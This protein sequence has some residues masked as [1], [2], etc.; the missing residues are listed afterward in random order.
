[1]F[2]LNLGNTKIPHNKNTAEM[3][4]VKM[5]PPG[6]VLLPMSQNIGAPAT[7]IVKVGEYVKVGQLIAE[8]SAPISSPIYASVSGTVTKIESYL[9]KDGRTVP[10]IRIESDGLMTLYADITPPILTDMYSFTDAITESGVVG[11]GGA[12]FPTAIKVGVSP[13]NTIHTIILNGA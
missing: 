10:A 11:L 1:M 6:E 7:P 3:K 9:K 2:R 8:P 13:Q 5:P 4:P 12:G